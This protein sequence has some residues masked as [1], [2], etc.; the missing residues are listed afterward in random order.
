MARASFE[1]VVSAIE[2]ERQYQKDKWGDLDERNNVADFVLYMQR[3]LTEAANLNDPDNPEKSL[4]VIR[5]VTSIG[6]GAMERHGV[7]RREGY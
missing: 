4:D 6:F 5:K 7:V 1:E 2:G 3:Y